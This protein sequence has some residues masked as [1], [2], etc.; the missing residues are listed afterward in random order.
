MTGLDLMMVSAKT[1]ENVDKAFNH[2]ARK[3]LQTS[4]KAEVVLISQKFV[5]KSQ[6]FILHLIHE[7]VTDRQMEGQTDGQTDRRPVRQQSKNYNYVSPFYWGGG[8]RNN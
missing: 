5:Q 8:S 6:V 3:V 1:G 2:L 7:S 4:P